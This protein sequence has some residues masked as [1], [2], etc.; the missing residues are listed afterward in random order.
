MSQWSL[1]GEIFHWPYIAL[2]LRKPLSNKGDEED[3]GEKETIWK[4]NVG[5]E[6]TTA[7]EF[8]RQD[9]TNLDLGTHDLPQNRSKSQIDEFQDEYD[10]NSYRRGKVRDTK[11]YQ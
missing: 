4:L 11:L 7:F 3:R 9:P 2:L 8:E 1:A 6:G 10:D 5:S